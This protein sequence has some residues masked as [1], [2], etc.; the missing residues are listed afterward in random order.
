MSTPSTR[1][2]HL[3]LQFT[4]VEGSPD[5]LG[6]LHSHGHRHQHHAGALG[7]PCTKRPEGWSGQTLRQTSM[8]I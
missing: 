6:H 5:L 8:V 2:M 4:T 7:T 3:L 1:T